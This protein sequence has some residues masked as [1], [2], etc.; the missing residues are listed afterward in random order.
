MA[1]ISND[2]GGLRRLLFVGRDGQRHAIRL[3]RLTKRQADTFKGYVEAL[4]G[5]AITGVLDDA[6]AEWVTGLDDITHDKLAA[7]GLVK[8]RQTTTAVKLGA[9]IDGFLER[10]TDIKL[11]TRINLLQARRWLVN[12]FGE[13]RDLANIGPAEAEDYRLFMGKGGLGENSIR[14]FIGRARQ[15]FKAAIRRGQYRR[16]NPFDGMAA[17]VRA[18]KAR[19]FY[20][21]REMAGKVLAVCTDAQ[22]R[23][24]FALSRFGGLRCPSEH[25]ALKWGDIDF[26]HGRIRV[27]S[28]KTEHHAG[29]DC[30]T[31]PMFPELRGPLMEVFEQ[32]EPGTE[33]VITRYRSTETNLRTQLERIVKR[34]GLEPWPKLWHNLRAS[35]QTEL[36]ERYPIHVVC[37]WIGNSRAVAQEH[38]LQVTDAHFANA[39]QN[40]AQHRSETAGNDEKPDSA[41]NANGPE[42]PMNSE[43][44]GY[45][46]ECQV[47]PTGI[48]PV[49]R[50]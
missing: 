32:A 18:D 10:H 21:T 44:C 17:T 42:F 22:W 20:V 5:Q 46:P 40:Q 19:Q 41:S 34:A 30:R 2:G 31:I 38:Y 47:T 8:S 35:R 27:P 16:A 25:L 24:L 23:L 48:E 37:A 39:A 49:L 4:I 33:W 43:P 14:R 12:C 6:T 1:S 7:V 15:M 26:E 13:G 50:P 36:A 29:K 3:G 9:F 28:P 45:L 11:G